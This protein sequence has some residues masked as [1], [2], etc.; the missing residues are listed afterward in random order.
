MLSHKIWWR[1]GRLHLQRGC[2]LPWPVRAR[3]PPQGPEPVPRPVADLTCRKVG[4][5]DPHARPWP[6]HCPL[7]SAGPSSG[8]GCGSLPQLPEDPWGHSLGTLAASQLCLYRA[9]MGG[10]VGTLTG[11]RGQLCSCHVLSLVA[12]C[13]ARQTDRTF[14]P[15]NQVGVTGSEQVEGALSAG[16]RRGQLGWGQPL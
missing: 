13:L 9:G 6:P 12:I 16:H 14:C 15:G 8:D 11:Q 10:G 7:Q 4:A 3:G 2:V 1:A 5:P